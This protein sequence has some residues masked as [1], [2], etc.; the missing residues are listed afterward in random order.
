MKIDDS[1]IL[2]NEIKIYNYIKENKIQ[3]NIPN[4]IDTGEFSYQNKTYNYI[5]IEKILINEEKYILQ[6]AQKIY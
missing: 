6:H 3:I 1:S 2:L 5:V 4:I